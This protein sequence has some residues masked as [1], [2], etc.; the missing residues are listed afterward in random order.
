VIKNSVEQYLPLRMKR[1]LYASVESN[2]SA[3]ANTR[4]TGIRFTASTHVETICLLNKI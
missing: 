3:K 4:F 1:L 2:V